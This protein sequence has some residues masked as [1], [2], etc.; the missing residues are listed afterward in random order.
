M[1]GLTG[2]IEFKIAYTI[3]APGGLTVMNPNNTTALQKTREKI[4]EIKEHLNSIKSE[5]TKIA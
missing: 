5:I 4:S 2:D 3:P 1:H